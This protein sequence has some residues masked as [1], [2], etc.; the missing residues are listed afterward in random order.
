MEVP[1]AA[2]LICLEIMSRWIWLVR[3][4]SGYG[5]AVAGA[6]LPFSVGKDSGCCPS[7]TLLD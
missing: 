7:C 2:V 3:I 5:M 4:M 6:K 1:A